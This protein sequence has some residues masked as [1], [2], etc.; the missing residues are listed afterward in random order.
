MR[1]PAST[2]ID[3][4]DLYERAAQNPDTQARFL[5]SLLR[6]NAQG[7]TL[8]EDFSGTGAVSRAWVAQD[9]TSRSVC[10]DIDQKP[11]ERLMG[12]DRIEIHACDV[13]DVHAPVDLLA[14]LNFSICEWPTRSDLVRYL[15]HSRGRL[16]SGGVL[17]MDIYG[18]SDAMSTGTYDVELDAASD[19]TGLHAVLY[20]W[21]QVEANPITGRVRNAMHFQLSDG[22]W[23]R[24]AFV[25]D[26]RLWSV[27]ELRDALVEAGF[28]EIEIHDSLGDAQ[29]D[30]GT[31]HSRAIELGN[32]L[33]DNYV[34]YIAARAAPEP[35]H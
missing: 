12:R 31:I 29:D 22:S 20:Q 25:Y 27:P 26:W 34:V 1:T 30:D 23:I 19:K 4:F 24:A 3:I 11:L 2:D 15:E 13:M 33:E 17:V 28:G 32:P 21:E 6:S 9:N 16:R 18:G 35:E 5:R 14:V 10:V 8:G 7:A